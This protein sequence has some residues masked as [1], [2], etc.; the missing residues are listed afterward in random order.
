MATSTAT[1][2]PILSLGTRVV[3]SAGIGTLRFVGPTNFAAGKWCGIEL[4]DATGKN[5]GS[6]NGQRYFTCRMGK[7]VFVRHSQVRLLVGGDEEGGS[8]AKAEVSLAYRGGGFASWKF[9]LGAHKHEVLG[10]TVAYSASK[11]D[12]NRIKRFG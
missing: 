11:R 12:Q 4:D 2:P 1:P 3:V 9:G 8:E 6:V 10:R 7:G 5:D